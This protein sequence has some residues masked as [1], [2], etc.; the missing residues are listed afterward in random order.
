ME[1]PSFRFFCFDTGGTLNIIL[2]QNFRP[3]L[4]LLTR[5][6]FSNHFSCGAEYS[7]ATG[8]VLGTG[9]AMRNVRSPIIILL[10][11]GLSSL[12]SIYVGNDVRF[13]SPVTHLTLY[14]SVKFLYLQN[15]FS[16]R[17]LLTVCP[18]Y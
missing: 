9:I 8:A 13:R 12:A 1:P 3:Q 15:E 18:H 11:T 4:A 5:L 6:T 7:M 10:T 2:T 14:T 17:Q 16:D